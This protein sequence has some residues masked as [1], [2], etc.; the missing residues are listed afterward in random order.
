MAGRHH[1]MMSWRWP[2]AW[3]RSLV[4][5][6]RILRGCWLV[7]MAGVKG[8]NSNERPTRIPKFSHEWTRMNTNSEME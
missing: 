5:W 6:W 2:M 1:P 8:S 7:Q 4:G 3:R